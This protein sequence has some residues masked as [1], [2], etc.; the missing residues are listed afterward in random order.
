MS[1]GNGQYVTEEIINICLCIMS[2]NISISHETIYQYIYKKNI[3]LAK[4]LLRR[5]HGRKPRN[6]RI[7]RAY[8]KKRSQKPH[9]QQPRR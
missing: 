5:K 6:L 7:Y 2:V 8:K 4:Y 3:D 9:I 1:K